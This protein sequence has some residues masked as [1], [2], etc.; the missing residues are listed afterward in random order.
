[1]KEGDS[2]VDILSLVHPEELVRRPDTRADPVPLVSGS[3]SWVV[4]ALEG[5]DDDQIECLG[6]IF[7][8]YDVS[9]RNPNLGRPATFFTLS[10]RG[11]ARSNA[12]REQLLMA[13]IGPGLGR[14]LALPP[15]PGG[16]IS[17]GFMSGREL[18][19]VR[20]NLVVDDQRKLGTFLADHLTAHTAD[21]MVSLM[22]QCRGYTN[23]CALALDM[24]G[25]SWSRRLGVEV[26]FA[27]DSL[28]QRAAFLH[29]LIEEGLC[30]PDKAAALECFE[31]VLTPLSEGDDWPDALVTRSLLGAAHGLLCIYATLSHFKLVLAP[32][33]ELSAKAY[34][35]FYDVLAE[36]E[37][38]L[39]AI[40]C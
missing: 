11:R 35:G 37:S 3:L 1:M 22:D 17:C 23:R 10:S 30:S 9:R 25:S 14:D 26:S 8:E 12:F 15:L 6:E 28:E 32:D 39:E 29:W 38:E 31:A 21:T 18:E 40:S 13:L 5:L 24:V 33:G 7:L 27:A 36:S 2:R 16:V 4:K 20:F 19:A 34:A